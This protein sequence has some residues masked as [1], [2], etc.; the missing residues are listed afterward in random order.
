MRGLK[1]FF[2]M[3]VAAV[4]CFTV[5]VFSGNKE[6]KIMNLLSNGQNKGTNGNKHRVFGTASN[7]FN[8]VGNRTGR[9][10]SGYFK[11]KGMVCHAASVLE[12]Q[13]RQNAFMSMEFKPYYENLKLAKMRYRFLG[14]GDSCGRL[15]EAS[16]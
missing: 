9:N 3:I 14:P 16:G 1:Q 4:V 10:V 2:R 8:S 5:S 12:K 11:N 7:V 6:E 13:M 15:Y